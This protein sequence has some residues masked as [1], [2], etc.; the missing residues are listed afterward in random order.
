MSQQ[1]AALG[2]VFGFIVALGIGL[3]ASDRP[4]VSAAIGFGGAGLGALIGTAIPSEPV[5][6]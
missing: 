4:G 6:G 3:A 5:S 2:G 1:G